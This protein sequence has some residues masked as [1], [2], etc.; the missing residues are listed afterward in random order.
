MHSSTKSPQ[1]LKKIINSFVIEQFKSSSEIVF[2]AAYIAE[3]QNIEMCVGGGQNFVAI[4]PFTLFYSQLWPHME[5]KEMQ[6]NMWGT[7]YMNF[8][9]L[10][11]IL[12][13]S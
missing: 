1:P 6:R 2:I 12:I 13:K 8:I 9:L 3:Y 11:G 5:L 10:M 7:I 4:V